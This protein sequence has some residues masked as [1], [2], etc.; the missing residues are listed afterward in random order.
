ML[1]FSHWVESNSFVT[2]LEYKPARLLCPWGF[3]RQEYCS[4][5][6]FPSLGNLPEPG[7]EPVLPASTWLGTWVLY[8]QATREAKKS[9]LT[10]LFAVRSS[11]LLTSFLR[12]RAIYQLAQGLNQTSHVEILGICIIPFSQ[13]IFFKIVI[14]V[15]FISTIITFYNK[16]VK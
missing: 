5:L 11:T 14:L 6:P 4:G 2:P 13:V 12:H 10:I 15:N 16:S 9:Q 7:I 3:P 8:H 1:L